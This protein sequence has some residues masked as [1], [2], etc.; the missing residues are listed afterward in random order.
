M[1][2]STTTMHRVST[3]FLSSKIKTCVMTR[4][5]PRVVTI[6]KNGLRLAILLIHEFFEAIAITQLLVLPNNYIRANDCP[7]AI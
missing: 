5:M 7:L 6:L 4:F 3:R 2:T 1:N